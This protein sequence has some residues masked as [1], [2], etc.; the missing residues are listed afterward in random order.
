M[1]KI[2]QKQNNKTRDEKNK[3]E[4]EQPSNFIGNVRPREIVKEME[5]SY[6]D[7]AISVIVSRALPDVRDGLKPV[8]RRILYA[9]YDMG[10]R[11]NV[12]FRKSATVVGECL[13]KYHPH[14][15]AA[16]YDSLVKMAQDFSLRYP[17]V[18][19]QG[20]FGCQDGDSAASMRYCITGDSFVITNHCLEKIGEISQQEDIS[21][22]VLSFN[23]KV[24]HASK[25]FDSGIHPIVEVKTLRG[26]SL[27]G[28]NNHPILTLTKDLFGK[29]IFQWKLL[30][31][32]EKDDFAVIDR[33]KKALW[34][35][36]EPLLRDFYPKTKGRKFKIYK[37]PKKMSPD[38]AFL[39]G[40][41]LAEGFI[42]I[43]KEKHSA[44]IGVC[45]TDK[46][47][48][49]EF[50]K[51]FKKLFPDCAIYQ[52]TREPLSYGKKKFISLEICSYYLAE[53]FENLGLKAAPSKDKEVPHIMF[54]ATKK[55]MSAFLRG[56]VE[57]DGTIFGAD[58]KKASPEIR[59][60]SASKKLLSQIQIILLRFGIDSFLRKDSKGECWFLALR[61]Y[62]NFKNFCEI[63]F[64]DKGKNKKLEIALKRNY[65]AYKEKFVMLK[66]DF[67]PFLSDYLRS[68]YKNKD[69]IQWNFREYLLKHNLDRYWKLNDKIDVLKK[70]LEP[71]D[72]LLVSEFLTNR[73]LFDSIVDKKQG[74]EERVYSFRVDSPCHSFVS[75]GFVSH[76]TECRLS[77]IGEE[78]LNDIGKNTVDFRPNYDATREEPKVLPSP[79]PQLLLNGSF[80]I[81]VGMATNIPPHNLSEVLDGCVYLVDNP[82]TTSEDLFQFIQG[83]DFPTGGIIYDKKNIISAYS[84]GKGAILTRGKADIQEQKK[85]DFRIII[86]EIPFQVQKSDLIKEFAQLV[87]DKKIEGIKNIRDESDRDGMRIVIDLKKDAFPKKVLNALYKYTSLQKTFY[88][89][90]LALVDEVQPKVLSLSEVLTLYLSHKK[91]VVIR[92]TK[93]DLEKAEE[94]AHILEGLMIALKNIDEIIATIKKSENR[95]DAK[96]NLIKKFALSE[97]QAIAIL[98]IKLQSLVKLEIE[99]IE[100]ELEEIKK[101]IQGLGLILKNPKKLKDLIKQ[102][103][104]EM[105]EK[106]GDKRKTKVIFSGPGEIGQEEL[107][108]SAETIIILTIGGFI[109]RVKPSLYKVQKRGG[110]GI[111]GL[112]I[113]GEDA[114]DHFLM[115][116]TLDKLL[117]FTDSGKVFQCQV[118]EIPEMSRTSKGR[119][120]LNFLE[121]SPSEKILDLIHYSASMEKEN[122]YLVIA[123]KNGVIKK[124][125][126]QEFKNVRRNGLTAIKLKEGDLLCGAKIINPGE[127]IILLTKKGKIIR[128][129]EKDLRSMGRATAGVRAIRLAKDDAVIAMDVIKVKDKK[130]KPETDELLLIIA[131]NGYGKRTKVR[132]YRIQKRGGSGIKA[133]KITE[134]TGEV[135]F[136]KV[137][138]EEKKDLLVISEKGQVMRTSIDSISILGRNA[139][140][141]KIMKL[142]KEDKIASAVCL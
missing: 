48:I 28:T 13:G 54:H 100:K 9:M 12:K 114:V 14:G 5:D 32:I 138:D 88:L 141:V 80:G 51:K 128:F 8:H 130:E 15:D 98:E 101:R 119:G 108:P 84:Q 24:N 112:E 132:E 103:L 6:L 58:K 95:E 73:Y 27:R 113:S 86:S 69:N 127:E 19:G 10:L 116:N 129:K 44:K 21:L 16:V 30:S 52:Q 105:K 125:G 136:A 66:N 96:K 53:F 90:M 3:H 72:R 64:F 67:I 118:W 2:P 55:S 36:T 79:L 121:T 104:L 142:N 7:Y 97:K 117:F 81:A 56:F 26:F 40:L 126:L 111:I 49:K 78:M 41:I 133:A 31:N 18:Q 102:E 23:G 75:N 59:F 42:G 137:L 46:L 94:R 74:E 87:E 37:M 4:E 120:L 63:G 93:Y 122:K 45:N 60:I 110:K 82:E 106:Y 29:P 140:G 71:E 83:P 50:I 25:L 34:P 89:N 124:T 99:K 123:T 47:L 68:K 76:N 35:K 65:L 92:R 131:T 107:I 135:I 39:L 85:D 109:K 139:S 43:N 11:H 38:L 61:G 1:P 62:D 70:I 57:G 134:K 17:S 33:N 91:E 22:D 20:N 115:A 77:R